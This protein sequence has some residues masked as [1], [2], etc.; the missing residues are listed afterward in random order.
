LAVARRLPGRIAAVRIPLAV[1]EGK[2]VSQVAGT[3]AGDISRGAKFVK[4][5]SDTR[6]D[7]AKRSLLMGN[8]LFLK[9][10]RLVRS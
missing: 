5:N 1:R 9:L 10:T 4:A 7:A 8:R 2:A 6:R 3:H